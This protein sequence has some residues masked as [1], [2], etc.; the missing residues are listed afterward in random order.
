MR[1]RRDHRVL[2]RRASMI[3]L[4]ILGTSLISVAAINYSRID[5]DF[6]DLKQ[7]IAM[8][9]AVLGDI[10]YL[11]DYDDGLLILNTSDP[12]H[13]TLIKE[14]DKFINSPRDIYIDGELA[15]LAEDRDYMLMVILLA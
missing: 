1:V 12:S 11:I 5:I 14:F 10:T 15:Y 3:I 4:C 7:E 8:D 9:V 13:P 6:W 2:K